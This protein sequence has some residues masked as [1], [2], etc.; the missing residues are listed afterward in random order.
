MCELFRCPDIKGAIMPGNSRVPRSLPWTPWWVRLLR[1]ITRRVPRLLKLRLN[2][3]PSHGGKLLTRPTASR[4]MLSPKSRRNM[5]YLRESKLLHA[6]TDVKGIPA[7]ARWRAGSRARGVVTGGSQP[8][9]LLA[10]YLVFPS[11]RLWARQTRL[12]IGRQRGS[13]PRTAPTPME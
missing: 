6:E 3:G 5:R 9:S 11:S 7:C 13:G 12:Q 2:L 10:S 4:S 8:A 1:D